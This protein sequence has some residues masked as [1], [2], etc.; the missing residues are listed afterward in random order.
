MCLLTTGSSIPDKDIFVEMD[1][2][3]G[4][5]DDRNSFVGGE[6]GFSRIRFTMERN[7][8]YVVTGLNDLIESTIHL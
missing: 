4:K 2:Y 6:G 7:V 1:V 3:G 8:E 5:G